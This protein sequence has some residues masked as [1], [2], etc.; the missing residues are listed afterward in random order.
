MNF[1]I[2]IAIDRAPADVFAFLRDIDQHPLE[3]C[4]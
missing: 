1:E 4:S 3:P 2:S